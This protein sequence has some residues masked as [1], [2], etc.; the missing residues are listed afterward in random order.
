MIIVI[1][2]GYPETQPSIPRKI[3]ILDFGGN[4]MKKIVLVL[5]LTTL[6]VLATASLVSAQMSEPVGS[7][8]G[9]FHLHPLMHDDE[10]EGEHI[11]V[12]VTQ[13]LNGDGHICAKHITPAG[14]IHVHV[15]NYLPLR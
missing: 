11:H 5:L 7:C 1:L 15:D 6:L 12:G 9:G 13:D 8:P 10:H 14:N 4:V 3:R 2:S